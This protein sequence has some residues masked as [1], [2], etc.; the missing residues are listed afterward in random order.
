M[1]VRLC[2]FLTS[3]YISMLIVKN[4]HSYISILIVKNPH[5]Y[6]SIL[7]VKNPQLEH[8]YLHFSFPSLLLFSVILI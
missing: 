6:I 3:S 1:V 8:C 4:P 5:S 7:I 2:S